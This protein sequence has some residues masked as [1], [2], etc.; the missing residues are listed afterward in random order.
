MRILHISSLWPPVVMGGAELYAARL[1]REQAAVG[2][3][4]GAVTSGVPGDYVIEDLPAWPY[5]LDR[6]AD[7]PAWRRATFHVLDLYNPLAAARMKR[8][9]DRFAPDV[10][11][12]HFVAG[13]S[14]A[15]VTAGAGSAARVHHLH[16]YWLMCRRTTMR[17]PNGE[18]CTDVSCRVVGGSRSLIVRSH[19]PELFLAPS[20]SVIDAHSHLPWTGGRM[21]HVP[22]PLDQPAPDHAVAVA[23]P[24]G[25]ATFGYLGQLSEP[26][27]IPTLLEAFASIAGDGHRLLV[28]GQGP[29]GDALGRAGPSVELLGWLDDR[30]KD[31]FFSRIHC[32]IVPSNYPETGPLVV[33]EA[34]AR[35]VPVIGSRL[36]GIPENVG[37]RCRP[38]LF[39]PGDAAELTNSIRRFLADPD[40]FSAP[41]DAPAPELAMTWSSHSAAVVALYEEA[42]SL[43]RLASRRPGQ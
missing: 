14:T 12:S 32:L 31:R 36:G 19:P 40:R 26:K 8:A 23:T 1:A 38:L 39:A 34:R 6:F 18:V 7:Q 5:R 42:I 2:H 16:G 43:R 28:G 21:R 20:Q 27:G 25:K 15:A 29:M 35:G 30:E 4:V 37:P 13:L 41:P 24:G 11:H 10:I 9:I 17:R 33:L 22:H 3:T